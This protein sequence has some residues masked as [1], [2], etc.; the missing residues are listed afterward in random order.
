MQDAT[1]VT[2]LTIACVYG[3]SEIARV[4]IE[5]GAIIDLIDKVHSVSTNLSNLYYYYMHIERS[6]LTL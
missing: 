2:P 6:F 5:H 1:G 4:L 3:N